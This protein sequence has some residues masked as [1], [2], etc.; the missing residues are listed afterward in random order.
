MTVYVP[1][2]DTSDA[3]DTLPITEE[4]LREEYLFGIDL[5][6]DRG[7]PLPGA[8]FQRAIRQAVARV[9]TAI[10][11]SV[12]PRRYQEQHDYRRDD[13][14]AWCWI[15]PDHVPILAVHKVAGQWPEGVDVITFPDSWITVDRLRHIQIRPIGGPTAL[16]IGPG[17]MFLPL[18][19][20]YTGQLPSF[21]DVEYT[22]GFPAGG[23]PEDVLAAISKFAAIELLH[24]AGDLILGAGIASQELRLNQLMQ[25]INTTA[26]PT[27]AGYGARILNY[28]Q[29]LKE[30]IPLIRDKYHGLRLVVV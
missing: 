21:F 3:T 15:E 9:E 5:G 28:K 19:Q 23:I 12:T 27:N 1:Q 2:P 20:G 6:D 17:S 18:I 22:A 13:Y 16:F 29:E 8:M 24:V 4:T 25:K 7:N 10:D 14:R 26:S 11:I 30:Q